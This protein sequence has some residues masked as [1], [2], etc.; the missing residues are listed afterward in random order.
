MPTP[1]YRN[2]SV[3]MPPEATKD[4][5]RAQA[6][7]DAWN[8]RLDGMDQ[9]AIATALNRRYNLYDAKTNYKAR[10]VQ[11]LLESTV[12]SKRVLHE[13][14][15]GDRLLLAEA[16]LEHILEN[17]W[18][19]ISYERSVREKWL[20]GDYDMKLDFGSQIPENETELDKKRREKSQQQALRNLSIMGASAGKNPRFSIPK[21]LQEA[22]ETVKELARF[23]GITAP[24]VAANITVTNNHMNVMAEELLGDPR[25]AE[26]GRIV[27]AQ[28]AASAT[29]DDEGGTGGTPLLGV[30][31]EAGC[32]E[33][34]YLPAPST[35]APLAE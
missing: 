30:G 23:Q 17:I 25:T 28:L 22:R 1:D 3:L 12:R 15:A 27:L 6:R 26:I 33:G 18:D 14:D 32:I 8:M 31:V 16:R 2:T 20:N 21:L 7:I 10:D 9:E 24:D 4:M 19:E 29:S 11:K 34:E 5:I 13:Q 35:G